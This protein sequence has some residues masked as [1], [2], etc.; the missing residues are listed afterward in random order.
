GALRQRVVEDLR[1]LGIRAIVADLDAGRK[2]L[3]V[4]AVVDIERVV[5]GPRVIGLPGVVA[6]LKDEVS[7]AVVAKDEDQVALIAVLDC[8]KLAEVDA[9]HPILGDFQRRAGFPLAFAQALL[10]DGGRGLRLSRE[11]AESLDVPPALA[12]VITE[13]IQVDHERRRRVGADVE[14]EFV[15]GANTGPRDK[16]FDQWGSAAQPPPPPR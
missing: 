6:T 14:V 8:G 12:L 16:A 2:N 11:R 4:L 13:T 15:A 1:V 5:V 10:A 9:A 7:R 3:A